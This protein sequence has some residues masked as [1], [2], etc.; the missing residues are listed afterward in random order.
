MVVKSKIVRPE[1]DEDSQWLL[2]VFLKQPQ[3]TSHKEV[4]R[5]GLEALFE[6]QMNEES[7]NWD[8]NSQT[9]NSVIYSQLEKR[10]HE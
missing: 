8:E 3:F 7:K 1:L 10:K 9:D 5:A 2:S 4:I 6:K